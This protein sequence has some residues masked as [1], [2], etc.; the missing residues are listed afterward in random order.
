MNQ[1]PGLLETYDVKNAGAFVFNKQFSFLLE[2][3]DVR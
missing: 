1:R 2:T 3:D